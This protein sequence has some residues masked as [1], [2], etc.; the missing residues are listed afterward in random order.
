MMLTIALA[1][2]AQDAPEIAP[3]DFARL[4]ALIR[5][6]AGESPWRDVEWMTNVRDAR[7]KAAAEGKPI[8]IFTAADGSPLS[9]T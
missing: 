9:R 2:L 7:R 4:H 5:P 6:Q 1:L 8:L 3:A